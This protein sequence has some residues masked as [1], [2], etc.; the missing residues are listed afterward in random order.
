MLWNDKRV[1]RRS[2]LGP[3]KD[4]NAIC[5]RVERNNVRARLRSLSK[6]RGNF[7]KEE[8]ERNVSNIPASKSSTLHFRD[9]LN[10]RSFDLARFSK[11]QDSRSWSSEMKRDVDTSTEAGS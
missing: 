5:A 1:L 11:H 6:K 7:E 9:R 10:S 2:A 8:K 3:E 4:R